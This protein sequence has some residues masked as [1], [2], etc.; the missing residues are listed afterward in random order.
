MKL[1][2]ALA[3]AG[4]AVDEVASSPPSW[5]PRC[6]RK[7][8]RNVTTLLTTPDGFELASTF[9]KIEDAGLRRSILE[10]ARKL[11]WRGP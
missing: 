4:L 6:C 1:N 9:P 7:H 2:T 5:S 11:A 10:L 3:F 8:E